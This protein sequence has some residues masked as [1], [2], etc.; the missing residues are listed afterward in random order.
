MHNDGSNKE[1][2]CAYVDRTQKTQTRTPLT[3]YLRKITQNES[4]DNI[5]L[6]SIDSLVLHH[7]AGQL[8]FQILIHR[9]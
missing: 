2:I 1:D 6:F 8:T 4:L 9:K 7:K 5:S 3:S